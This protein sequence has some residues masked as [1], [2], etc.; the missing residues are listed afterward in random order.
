MTVVE[1]VEA[2]TLRLPLAEDLRLGAMVIRERDY[3][4]VRVTTSDGATGSA[5]ALSRGAPVDLAVTELAARHI[6]GLDPEDID[7]AWRRWERSFISLGL[8]GILARAVSLLDVAL[9]DLR[10]RGRGEPLWRL[11]GSARSEAEVMLVEGYPRSTESAEEFAERLGRRADEGYSWLKIANI[12]DLD[13]MTE[14]LRATRERC[15]DT[16]L[17]ID[18]AWAWSDPAIAADAAA[19]WA[20]LDLDW[21]EDPAPADEV[22]FI[23]DLRR[24]SATRIGVGDEV[25]DPLRM[26]G[27]VSGGAIDVVR[28]DALAIGG[29]TGFLRAREDATAAGLPVSP[30]IYPELHR[31]LVFAFEN[32]FPVESYGRSGEFDRSLDFLEVEDGP[33]VAAPTRPG[34]GIEIDWPVVQAAARRESEVGA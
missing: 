17:V 23:R 28:L 34:A 15:P 29:V 3:V 11:L 4:V 32:V 20:D 21:I 9:W 30:H 7:E 31:H 10:A 1:R 26:R 5:Y 6:L 13:G 16:H 18:I 2:W 22:A 27:L 25:S 24:A 12:P 14:R 19:R 8:T 33:V